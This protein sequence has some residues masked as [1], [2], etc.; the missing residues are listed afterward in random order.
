C[1]LTLQCTWASLSGGAAGFP[2]FHRP[3]LSAELV[4]FL[5]SRRA[6]PAPLRAPKSSAEAAHRMAHTLGK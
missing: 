4:P 2:N 3:L 5:T 6:G 1:S